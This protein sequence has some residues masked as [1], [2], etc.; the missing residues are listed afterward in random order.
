[1]LITKAST[2]KSY[3]EILKGLNRTERKRLTEEV[4]RLKVPGISNK[5]L[6][7]YVKSGKFDKRYSKLSIKKTYLDQLKD[8]IGAGIAI[9]GSTMSGNIHGIAVG[10]WEKSHE[11]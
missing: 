7:K 3:A 2:T 8:T 10:I 11:E 1:M 4:I 9:S 6:K 5:L